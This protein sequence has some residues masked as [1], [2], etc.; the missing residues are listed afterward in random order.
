MRMR[1]VLA[2]GLA[3]V[4]AACSSATEETSPTLPEILPT[5]TPTTE[6]EPEPEPEPDPEPA[7]E[8]YLWAA[9]DCVDLGTDGAIDLPYAPYGT[10]L[11]VDCA[12]PHTHEVYFDATIPA[13][14]S[15]PFP[16]DLDVGLWDTCFLEFAHMMG[17]SAS[18]STLDLTLY[19]PDEEEW[20]AGE[21][22][23]AC[24]MHR[25]AIDTVYEHLEGSAADDS[26]AYRWEVAAGTCHDVFFPELLAVADAVPCSE[27]HFFEVIGET[28]IGEADADYPGLDAVGEL[29][30]DACDALL[31][32]YALQSLDD[33]PVLTFP[34]PT[35]VI[36]GEWE[37][38]KRTVRC[39]AFAGTVDLGLLLVRGSLGDGSFELVDVDDSVTA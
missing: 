2:C 21:R 37:G 20:A 12:D 32:E 9:G 15:A 10:D 30:A 25:P 24:V 17:Y 23:H 35:V 33:L 11:L 18:D 22:Y 31:G 28:T 27:V 19:L 6:A 29:S 38:G 4:I 3:L 16:E 5:L 39:V 13:G 34:I 14:P 36:E 7:E 26:T 1:V 8:V